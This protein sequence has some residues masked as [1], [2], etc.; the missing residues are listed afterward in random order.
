MNRTHRTA[1]GALVA[2]ALAGSPAFGVPPPLAPPAVTAADKLTLQ[3]LHDG[4]QL[5]IQM[6]R[7]ALDKGSTRAMRDYARALVTDHTFAERQLD[8]YLRR[9]GTDITALGSTTNADP[10]HE[11]LATKSG[12]DFDRAFAQQMVRDH[13][14]MLDLLESARVETPDDELRMLYDRL[15]KTAR[16][17][18]RG[19]E[20]LLAAMSRS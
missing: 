9:R 5:E 16:A 20:D 10:E 18:R 11:L 7:L 8:E 14:R 13:Q 17:H 4:N 19:A 15:T 2:L 1:L 3:K 6:G 12:P